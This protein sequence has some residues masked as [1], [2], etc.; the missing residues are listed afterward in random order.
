MEAP[1]HWMAGP[2]RWKVAVVVVAEAPVVAE[3]TAAVAERRSE[4]G[5]S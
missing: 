2:W 4:N 1:V 5:Q 3:D